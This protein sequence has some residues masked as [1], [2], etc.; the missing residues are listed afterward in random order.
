MSFLQFLGAWNDLRWNKA[1]AVCLFD[2]SKSA[3]DSAIGLGT[4]EGV[5]Q[6]LPLVPGRLFRVLLIKA[7]HFLAGPLSSAPRILPAFKGTIS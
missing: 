6:A 3:L 2:P 1:D 7:S 5:Q 4:G